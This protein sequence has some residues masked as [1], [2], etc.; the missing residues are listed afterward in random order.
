[1]YQT[2]AGIYER[3]SGIVEAIRHHA[4]F[5]SETTKG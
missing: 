3:L 4:R 5:N 2:H 1:M